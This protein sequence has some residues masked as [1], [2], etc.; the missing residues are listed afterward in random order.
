MSSS[1]SG[2]GRGA[3]SHVRVLDLTTNHTGYGARLLSDLGA[4]VCRPVIASDQ[5]REGS[6]ADLFLHAGKQL[7]QAD[8]ASFAAFAA[9]TA[10]DVIFESSAFEPA[11]F[12]IDIDAIQ[13]AS[14]RSIIVSFSPFGQEQAGLPA[15]DL[16][17]LASGGLLSLGGY[18]DTEPVAVAGEQS[19]LASGIFGAVAALAALLESDTRTDGQWID[20]S[21][22]ECV[23]FALE[24][25]VPDYYINGRTRRRH[26]DS[27]REAGTGI[28]RCKDG[29]VSIVAGRLGTAKA[30]TT[31]RGWILAVG[32]PGS[33]AL[34]DPR[35]DDFA[36]RGQKE[37]IDQFARIFAAFGAQF[38]KQ[39]LYV[40]GQKR[41]IAIAPVNSIGDLFSDPQLVHS[42]FFKSFTDAAGKELRIPGAPYRLSATP[43][44]VPTRSDFV[45][46]GATP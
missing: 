6:P 34:A 32:T 38:S 11:P 4:S 29:Y 43:A 9:S 17:I 44:I 1:G 12:S 20:V 7:T 31:L 40:E 2:E 18:P 28:Y 19:L 8:P 15:T 10:F 25:A 3:L 13:S 42:G 37:N 14:P 39:E 46:A 22:Q 26:G 24:D 30:W 36:F 16:T 23:A 21:A 33:D 41:Q 5:P 35:W 27:A 45:L